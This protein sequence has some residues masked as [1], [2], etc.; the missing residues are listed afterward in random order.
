VLRAAMVDD[1]GVV[2]KEGTLLLIEEG[3][4]PCPMGT[5]LQP[6]GTRALVKSYDRGTQ[7]RFTLVDLAKL[8]D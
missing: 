4:V 6:G 8:G 1:N 3:F 2:G 5:L 7:Y